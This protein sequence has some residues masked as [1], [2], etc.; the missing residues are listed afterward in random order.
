MTLSI[1]DGKGTPVAH[2]F[3]QDSV[4]NGLDP[5]LHVNRA[6][7]N[8]PSFWE[9]ASSLIKIGSKPGMKHVAKVKL[10]RPIAGVDALSQPI[11]LGTHEAILTLLIDPKVSA[12]AD[13][14]DTLVLMANLADDATF[15]SQVK[16]LAPINIP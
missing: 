8:G 16:S 1:N 14:L 15:R 5:T 3:T 13:I 2:V 12:E 10:T 4:Q 7:T 9:R 11:V 6:N